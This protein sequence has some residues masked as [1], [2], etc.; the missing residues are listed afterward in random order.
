MEN[1][2]KP[3]SELVCCIFV[4]DIISF[5]AVADTSHEKDKREGEAVK[6][7]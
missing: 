7:L 3:P 5:L 1:E 4:P 2:K 6:A